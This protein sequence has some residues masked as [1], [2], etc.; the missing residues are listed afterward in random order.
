MRRLL[1][2]SAV[3]LSGCATTPGDCDPTRADFFSGISCESSGAYNSRDMTLR[4]N[5]ASARANLANSRTQAS[6]ANADAGAALDAQSRAGAALSRLRRQNASL[7]ARLDAAAR[8]D[9]VN[10]AA[11]NQQR[12]ELD[13]L[14]R[15]RATMERTGASPE[16]IREMQ[17]RQNALVDAARSY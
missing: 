11:V 10:L 6:D 7:R 5:L 2:L 1:L 13:R 8:R 14:E 12:A 16:A 15:E 4:S 3:F 17:R 9:G